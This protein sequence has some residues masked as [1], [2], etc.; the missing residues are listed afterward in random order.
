MA[1]PQHP[2][3]QRKGDRLTNPDSTAAEIECDYA[4]APM[5]R[6]ATEM[7]MR[8]GIDQLPALVAPA[9]AQKYGA[10]IAHLNACIESRDPAKTR[11]AA[12][13]CIRGLT[14]MDAEAKVSG[15]QPAQG[16]FL[17][18]ELPEVDGSPPFRF[19]ILED[20][21]EWMV[22]KDKRP[23]LRFYTMREIAVALQHYDSR[24]A[25]GEV[26]DYFP[27]ARVTKI[28]SDF[29][30]ANGGDPMPPL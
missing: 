14:A 27:G 3:R 21:N 10:A 12:E 16:K 24:F 2:R 5:D 15:H 11:A 6:L 13:N 19:A 4:L 23:D 20:G 1:N 22:A 30:T 9:T 25:I 17:E 29:T 28:K 7:E 18:Y 26:K 8:W